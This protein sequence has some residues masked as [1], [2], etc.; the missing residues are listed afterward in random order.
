[1]VKV[2]CNG[3]ILAHMKDNFMRV[4][5]MEKEHING[6]MVDNLKVIIVTTLWKATVS[7]H[8]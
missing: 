3:Q 5:C 2:Y 7:L 6:K 1:M 8:G 4:I